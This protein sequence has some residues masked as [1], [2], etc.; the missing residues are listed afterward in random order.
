[1]D[2]F[3]LWL[4]TVS[5]AGGCTDVHIKSPGNP[6]IGGRYISYN[7][8][9]DRGLREGD[10]VQASVCK[11]DI[12]GADIFPS[13]PQP[14]SREWVLALA[15]HGVHP[16]DWGSLV[17]EQEADAAYAAWAAEPRPQL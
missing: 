16:N 4:M 17:S 9:P 10:P 13:P 6:K 12:T 8:R 1:M 5:T 7:E 15:S 3:R 11:R 2:E 14:Y